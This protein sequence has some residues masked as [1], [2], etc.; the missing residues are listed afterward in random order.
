[1]IF[2]IITFLLSCLG[3]GTVVLNNTDPLEKQEKIIKTTEKKTYDTPK[4][5]FI[6]RHGTPLCAYTQHYNIILSR[7]TCE[8]PT[9]EWLCL[10]E[11][12]FGIQIYEIVKAFFLRTLDSKSTTTE[13]VLYSG[14]TLILKNISRECFEQWLTHI[15]AHPSIK[16]IQSHYVRTPLYPEITGMWLGY[17]TGAYAQRHKNIGAIGL[18]RYFGKKIL[19]SQHH[20]FKEGESSYTLDQKQDFVISMDL[21]WQRAAFKALSKH[22]KASIVIINS[23]TGE[24]LAAVSKPFIDTLIF[25]QNS[26]EAQ[27]TRQDL[28]NRTD[29]PFVHRSFSGLYAPGSI[30][31]I[32]MALIALEKKVIQPK[33]TVFCPGYYD[34]QGYRFYCYT[35]DGHGHINLENAITQSCAVFF[36]DLSTKL[37]MNDIHAYALRLGLEQKHPTDFIEAKAGFVPHP[38][39]CHLKKKNYKWTAGDVIQTGIGQGLWQTTP[40]ALAIM[41]AKILTNKNIQATFANVS[42]PSEYET[43][44][45]KPENIAF[46]KKAL[47][48]VVTHGTLKDKK[49]KLAI[50][51]KTGTSQIVSVDAN[52][53]TLKQNGQT[54]SSLLQDH[55]KDTSLFLGYY[56]HDN[57]EVVICV[58]VEN[59]NWGSEAAWKVVSEMMQNYLQ[60]A[61]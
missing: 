20:Y 59:G 47:R 44:D 45:F 48:R 51:G 4:K 10:Y 57:P 26:I 14:D 31:K 53:R 54:I 19:Q 43:M 32:L 28:L 52:M 38:K 30:I 3:I 23:K 15:P 24:V 46:L 35:N 13:N 5:L 55:Q 12:I 42:T 2:S 56:P 50:A 61:S 9:E 8:T 60:V 11:K 58:V 36:Y 41:M 39:Y 22:N 25:A 40:V 33:D 17:E 7:A 16:K 27:Q 37:N 1:M 49:T 29:A 34:V 6:D 18:E 21:R